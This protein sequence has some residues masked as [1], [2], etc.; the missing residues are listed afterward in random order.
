V[1]LGNPRFAFMTT[2]QKY[3][4]WRARTKGISARWASESKAYRGPAL[5]DG[6][7]CLRKWRSWCPFEGFLV[8]CLSGKVPLP[9]ASIHRPMRMYTD[10]D[11]DLAAEVHR[12]IRCLIPGKWPTLCYRPHHC[13]P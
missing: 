6:R 11:R 8:Q 4:R 7:R 10:D 5:H 2:G 3:A 9:E 1:V 12:D 13:T